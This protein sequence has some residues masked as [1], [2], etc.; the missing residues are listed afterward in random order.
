M[1]V[2]MPRFG[3]QVAPCFGYAATITV[4]TIGRGKVIDEVDFCLQSND[5]LDRFRLLRD[6]QVATL[7]CGGLEESLEDLL[8]A[9][10]V[11]VI[12][13]VSGRVDALLERF[14]RG[15]LVAGAACLGG[16]T[17]NTER[18]SREGR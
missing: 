6:Q 14:L 7:I 5:I 15:E 13:W 4:F 16:P 17:K 11:R 3:E 18:T 2:A 12:S 9:N 10:D 1:R 8:Q